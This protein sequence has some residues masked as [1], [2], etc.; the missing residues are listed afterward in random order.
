MDIAAK[1][2]AKGIKATPQ[3]RLVYKALEELCHAPVDVIIEK[4]QSQ[5]PGITVSTIYR[6][7]D[8]FC[9]V[10]LF[11]R[12]NHPSGKPYFDITPANHHHIY[13]KNCEV[14]DYVDEELTELI[15]TRLRSGQFKDLDIEQV[16]V[17]VFA[18]NNPNKVPHK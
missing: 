15:K 9:E 7:L 14:L 10:G 11:V 16:S 13:T 18:K 1:I 17:Q 8:S 3:R 4:V 2:R 12:F 6:I 5:S